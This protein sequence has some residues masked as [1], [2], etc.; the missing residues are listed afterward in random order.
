V[1]DAV[2]RCLE[3]AR[4]SPGDVNLLITHQ[5]NQLF[6][7]EW[8]DRIGIRP[9]RTHDTLERYGNLF[10]GSIPITLADALEQGRVRRG[11]I[12]ALATFSNGGDF[13]SAMILS[14]K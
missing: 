13:V 12:V 3:Q 10:Q 9:P 8:R 14:W 6:L 7:K 11:D 4:M 5:P 1:P 2:A